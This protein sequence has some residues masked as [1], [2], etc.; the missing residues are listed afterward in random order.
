MGQAIFEPALEQMDAKGARVFGPTSFRGYL[1]RHGFEGARR[2]PK[3][4]SIDFVDSLASELR[5]ACTMVF[6]LGRASDGPGTQFALVRAE[7]ELAEF[8]LV[9]SECFDAGHVERF[10][11]EANDERMLG[12]RALPNLSETSLVNLGLASGVMSE[13]LEIDD[14]VAL[15]PPATGRS[16]FTFSFRPHS[17]VDEKLTHD[18]GQ[19]EVDTLFAERRDDQRVLFVIEAKTGSKRSSLAKHKLA[20][21][22]YAIADRVPG[23]VDIVPV[24]L[25]I[26]R[27]SDAIH[28]HIVECS[29]PDPR[30]QD[31]AVDELRARRY[32]EYVLQY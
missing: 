30:T 19:V 20:Y 9:D 18:S 13:A 2:T 12:F 11:S 7:S 4:I 22:V 16:T 1:K 8:F 23:E 15:L 17:S 31:P 25:R 29:F 3:Y 6:R 10:E 5:N 28:Y 27:R 32:R 21:P 14:R 24:Y 26:V